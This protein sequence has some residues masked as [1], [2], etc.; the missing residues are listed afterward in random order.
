MKSLAQ[1]IK[2]LAEHK[3]RIVDSGMTHIGL[4]SYLFVEI[5]AV[6]EAYKRERQR[7][8]VRCA[9]PGGP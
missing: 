7:D 3:E 1:A 8:T 5:D 9:C 2:E 6:V 4:G